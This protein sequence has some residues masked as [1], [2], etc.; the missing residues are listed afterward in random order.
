M[1]LFP[2]GRQA[3]RWLILRGWSQISFDRLIQALKSPGTNGHSVKTGVSASSVLVRRDNGSA[4]AHIVP[5]AEVAS[6]L[7]RR[8]PM[9]E[10]SEKYFTIVYGVLNTVTRVFRYVSA[11]HPAI[12][13]LRTGEQPQ[14]L[15]A[16]GLA[17]GWVPD[18]EYEEH[19]IELEPGDRLWLYSDGVPEAMDS[20]L[21]QF[22]DDRLAEAISRHASKPLEEGVSGLQ[23][24]VEQWCGQEGPK[25]D[26]SILAAE[27][28]QTQ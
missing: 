9:E 2:F 19:S 3:L 7:N 25:D 1:T 5:P 18:V 8:F 23:G 21:E 11:G 26:V 20:E 28:C 13:R 12:M 17:I 14:P 22:G 24:D 6:E 16:Q 10:W 27:I 4:E 15:E